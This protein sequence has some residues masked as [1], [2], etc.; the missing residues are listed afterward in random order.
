MILKLIYGRKAYV[1]K[2]EGHFEVGDKVF[3]KLWVHLE[4]V[5]E[6]VSVDLVQVAVGERAYAAARLAHRLVL[7][8]VL[9]KYIVLPYGNQMRKTIIH[10]TLTPKSR[11]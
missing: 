1:S 9:S 7:G 8:D 11:F 6:V 3:G 4:N 5:E 2:F 10:Y